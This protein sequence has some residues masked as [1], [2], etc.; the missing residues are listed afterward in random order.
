MAVIK[1]LPQRGRWR[2]YD[3]TDEKDKI[4]TFLMLLIDQIHM[5][6]LPLAQDYFDE[7]Q[8][9]SSAGFHSFAVADGVFVVLLQPVRPY[10]SV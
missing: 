6:L 9:F 1:S 3:A 2:G 4:C 7:V 10:F 8:I 5:T